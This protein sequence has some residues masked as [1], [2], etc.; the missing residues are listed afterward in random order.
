[1]KW[2]SPPPKPLRSSVSFS[3]DAWC[4][5]LTRILIGLRSLPGRTLSFHYD[6]RGKALLAWRHLGIIHVSGIKLDA[7]IYLENE[8]GDYSVS[9]SDI[10]TSVTQNELLGKLHPDLRPDR[11]LCEEAKEPDIHEILLRLTGRYCTI[12]KQVW[13]KDD[14]RQ[15]SFKFRGSPRLDSVARML[16]GQHVPELGRSKI[17]AVERVR[18]HLCLKKDIY[19][20]RRGILKSCA[21]GIWSQGKVKIRIDEPGSSE[22]QCVSIHLAS[23]DRNA[24]IAAKL[25]LDNVL[26]RGLVGELSTPPKPSNQTHRLAL[27]KTRDYINATQGGIANAKGYLGE[28]VLRLDTASEPPAI[29]VTGDTALLRDVQRCLLPGGRPAQH[30]SADCTICWDTA[31]DF[32]QVEECGHVACKECFVQYCTVSRDNKFPLRCFQE[33]CK[34]LLQLHQIRSALGEDAFKRLTS[35]VVEHYFQQRPDDYIKCPGP[36]CNA[37]PPADKNEVHRCASCFVTSCQECKAEYHHGETCREYKERIFGNMEQLQKW[38]DKKGAKR[39]PRCK[40]IVQ[41]DL[42]CKNGPPQVYIEVRHG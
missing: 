5:D 32:A 40:G 24:L 37:Y 33:N 39:C 30:M 42:G 38:M 14:E 28:N 3:S 31:E 18:V 7:K 29:V 21:H 8:Q 26:I 23:E 25:A 16:D 1:M 27:S 20:P 41:K 11:I 9:I 22:R 34:S 10:P 13:Y 15:T 4:H 36:D 12:I 35:E 6:S 19:S 2:A 17:H